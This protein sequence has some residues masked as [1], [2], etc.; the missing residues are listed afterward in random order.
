MLLSKVPG[1][2]V[3][4]VDECSAVDGTWGMKAQHY[5]LG[6][7][8]C[9]KL[10]RGLSEESFDALATDCPLSGQ[11]IAGE[12]GTV[13]FHPIELLNRAYGLPEAGPASQ[14]PRGAAP[15]KV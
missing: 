1:T 6:R 10:V 13:A 11:R 12:L 2:E 15:K 5:E 9:Q 4:T 14:P 8:Y 7:Q 3:T